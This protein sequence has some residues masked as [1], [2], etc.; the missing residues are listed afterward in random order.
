MLHVPIVSIDIVMALSS[1]MSNSI[2]PYLNF[3]ASFPERPIILQLKS[4]HMTVKV[5]VLS[6]LFKPDLFKPDLFKP[7]LFKPDLF[8]LS[9]RVV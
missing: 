8:M 5:L 7:D 4:V 9:V 1:H 6:D 3:I 2:H